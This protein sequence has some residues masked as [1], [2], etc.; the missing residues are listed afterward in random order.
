[1]TQQT[2]GPHSGAWHLTIAWEK[3]YLIA[4]LHFIQAI[5]ASTM[6][7]KE[8]LT[9]NKNIR[10]EVKDGKLTP[11]LQGSLKCTTKF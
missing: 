7:Y 8:K 2:K 6:A 4:P 11:L 10:N 3:F 5:L 9:F 1:M